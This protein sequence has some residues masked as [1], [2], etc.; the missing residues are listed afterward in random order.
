[1]VLSYALRNA[2]LLTLAAVVFFCWFGGFTGY[3][4]GW[5][6]Y[7]FGM[8]YPLRF[9][10]AAL[11]IIA[12][13]VIHQQSERGPLAP[14]RGFFKVWLSGGLFFA[15][16]ALWLLSLF[17]N[18]DLESHRWHLSGAAELALFNLLWAGLNGIL[19]WLGARL[20]MRMLTGYGATFLIIQIY[21]CSSLIWPK[22]WDDFSAC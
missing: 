20:A 18:F 2:L 3:A 16:M 4:S 10:A 17:G 1:M 11:A 15:E 8:S 21:T 19:I 9:L 13:A 22:A 14:Y 5:G 12:V 6:A 7:W